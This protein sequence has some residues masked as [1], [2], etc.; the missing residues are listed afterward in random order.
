MLQFDQAQWTS[1]NQLEATALPEILELRRAYDA[2]LDDPGL[3]SA[4]AMALVF[5]ENSGQMNRDFSTHRLAA[6]Q[7]I[8]EKLS[9]PDAAASA[10]T[11]G[12]VLLLVGVEV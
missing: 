9:N 1:D 2:G 6:I 7:H 8:N 4:I 10:A 3:A 11:I 12:A 5:A